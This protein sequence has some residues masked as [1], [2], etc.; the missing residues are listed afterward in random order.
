MNRPPS[1]FIGRRLV[2]PQKIIAFVRFFEASRCRKVKELVRKYLKPKRQCHWHDALSNTDTV[3]LSPVVSSTCPNDSQRFNKTATQLE[4]IQGVT[5]V[6]KMNALLLDLYGA[7]QESSVIEFHERALSI[8]KQALYFDSATIITAN[9]SSKNEMAV[10]SIHAHN[11]P[12]EKLHERSKLSSPDTVL[13]DAYKQRG[14][15]LLEDARNID[16]KEIDLINYCK[17]Y[18]V[19]HTLVLVP[20]ETTRNDVDLLALWRA[21]Q[22]NVYSQQD[23]HYGQMM[24]PHL[25]Q[26]RAINRRIFSASQKSARPDRVS[27]LSDLNGCLYFVESDAISLLQTEWP[28]W[29]PPMLP[30]TLIETLRSSRNRQYLGKSIILNATVEGNLLDIQI[31]SRPLGRMLTRSEQTVAWL[32]SD[33]MSYKT[34]AKYLGNSPATVRNQLHSV[35]AKL[36]ISNKS[37]LSQTLRQLSDIYPRDNP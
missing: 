19:A 7:A 15:L 21:K 8:V 12:L 17:K 31:S 9:F 27:L 4:N 13:L 20:K 14:N 25:F 36:E 33:G 35:Y 18:E 10:R 6:E 11:Q 26:A 32:A 24:L 2:F 37:S 5:T 1:F 16:K 34:I 30:S 22:K 29:T 3:V 23:A 28:E